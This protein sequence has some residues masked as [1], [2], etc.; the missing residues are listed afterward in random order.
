[1]GELSAAPAARRA[2]AV[3]RAGSDD[4]RAGQPDAGRETAARAGHDHRRDGGAADH[5]ARRQ[6]AAV[7]GPER[8]LPVRRRP[9][10]ADGPR[11]GGGPAAPPLATAQGGPCFTLLFAI[12]G[13]QQPTIQV[14]PTF[15]ARVLTIAGLHWQLS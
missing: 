5:R 15:T 14:T 7:H 13:R 3:H 1:P 8:P 10:P 9:N 2:R 12:G 11:A 4:N 6:P